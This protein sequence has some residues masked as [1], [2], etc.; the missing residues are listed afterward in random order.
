MPLHARL[1]VVHQDRNKGN[2]YEYGNM[3]LTKTPI[4]SHDLLK[5]AIVGFVNAIGLLLY[6]QFANARRAVWGYFGSYID[7]HR[8]AAGGRCELL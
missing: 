8:V 6:H 3:N 7:A 4:N 1:R 5:L 2:E